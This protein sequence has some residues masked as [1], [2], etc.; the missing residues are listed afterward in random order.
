MKK[1]KNDQNRTIALHPDIF[2]KFKLSK[3]QEQFT[4]ETLLTDS[5]FVW[6][7]LE[8]YPDPKKKDQRK[9]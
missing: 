9:S 3:I 1:K 7:L 6:H 2:N 8:S 5:M 4:Q